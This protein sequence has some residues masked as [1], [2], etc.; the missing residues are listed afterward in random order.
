MPVAFRV[1]Q[2][3]SYVGIALALTVIPLAARG[4]SLAAWRVL[5][6]LV[7]VCAI[8]L[9]AVLGHWVYGGIVPW[10][11]VG[12]FYLAQLVVPT[13]VAGWAAS[14]AAVRWP[15]YRWL[16]AVGTVVGVFVIAAL[17][18]TRANL[19]PDMVNAVQ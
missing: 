9:V 12:A 8:A 16:V 1:L 13:A 14:G 17:V 15:A 4:A 2:V 3:L 5:A 10:W 19:L 6:L 7:A 18:V 11:R